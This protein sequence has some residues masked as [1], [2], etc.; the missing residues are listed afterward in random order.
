MWA[1]HVN[2]KTLLFP[3]LQFHAALV[4]VGSSHTHP[5]TLSHVGVGRS[6]RGSESSEA[7]NAR[8]PK[9]K[10]RGR[11]THNGGEYP[12]PKALVLRNW[13]QGRS[14]TTIGDPPES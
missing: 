7:C 14:H 8:A 10:M 12:A 6:E 5:K 9:I 2:P 4:D 13:Q 3:R 11:L 1:S